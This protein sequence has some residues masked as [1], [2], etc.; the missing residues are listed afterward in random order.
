MSEPN[1]GLSIGQVAELTGLS[2]HALRFY[3]REGILLTS[4]RRGAGGRRVYG[5]GDV[6]WLHLCVSLRASGMPLP[7]IR[8]YADLV[9]RGAGNEE[10]LLTL[11]RQQQDRVTA[12]IAQL[13]GT[14]GLITHK[15]SSYTRELAQGA[16]G[17]ITCTPP[18]RT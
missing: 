7:A 18:P 10:H 8:Q 14:L 1:Q 5:A 6:E 2:V 11:L 17:P 16:T 4:V 12:Q 13:T 9:R 15:I 3:E